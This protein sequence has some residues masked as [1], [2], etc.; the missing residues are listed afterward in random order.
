MTF[1]K[2]KSIEKY[3]ALTAATLLLSVNFWAWSLVS[4]LATQYA[5]EFSLSP[6]MLSVLVAMPVMVGSLGRIPLGLLADRYGGRKIFGAVCMLAALAVLS[7]SLASGENQLFLAAVALG[8]AGASFAAGVPFV[9]AWFPKKERGLAL[10]IYALGNA[11]TAVSGL[12]TPRAAMLLGRTHFFWL[13]AVLVLAAGVAMWLFGRESAAWRPAKG[14][15]WRRLQRALAWNLT[16]RLSLL[17]AVTFG[18]FVALGLYLPVLLNQSYGL[19]PADAARRAAGFV[20][21]ATLVRPAG[22]WLSDRLSGL[23]VIRAAFLALGILAALAALKP[24]LAPVGTIAYLGMAVVLGIGNGAIFAVIGH[25]CDTKIVGTVTGV[26]GAAGGL[27]G[28]FPPLIMGLS[29]QVFHAYT[30]ALLLLAAVSF[31]VVA[32]LHRLFGYGKKY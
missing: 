31:V 8:I 5:K 22:G 20:L 25:R 16:W 4:P 32:S 13:L 11:G 15:G 6:F 24:G 18:A 29:F 27:G 14:S 1:K 28:Y 23:V 2:T 7:L 9:N 30:P 17:Y 21:L 19:D 26:V 12:L 3:A 10:G